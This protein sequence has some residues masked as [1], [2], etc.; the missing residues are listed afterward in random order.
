MSGKADSQEDKLLAA[1]EDI[2]FSDG[3]RKSSFEVIVPI[4]VSV[5]SWF[6]ANLSSFRN[7]H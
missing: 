1:F 3:V 5:W 4:A 6:S 2:A 7:L